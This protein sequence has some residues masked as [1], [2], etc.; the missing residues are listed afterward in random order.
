MLLKMYCCTQCEIIMHKCSILSIQSK[1]T[2]CYN[3]CVF[4]FIENSTQINSNFWYLNIL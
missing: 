4:L 2:I 3:N 1:S